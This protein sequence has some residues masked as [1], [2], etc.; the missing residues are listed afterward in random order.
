MYEHARAR[1]FAFREQDEHGLHIYSTR[2]GALESRGGVGT[3]STEA[4][5]AD[6][7]GSEAGMPRSCLA[8]GW[9]ATKPSKKASDTTL[10]LL[11]SSSILLLLLL[12]I[13][14]LLLLLLLI[15][16]RLRVHPASRRARVTQ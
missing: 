15:R 4:L 10:F 14:L 9:R 11:R 2:G 13:R 12:L 3:E 16:L 8:S 1:A 5:G 6:P 7:Q